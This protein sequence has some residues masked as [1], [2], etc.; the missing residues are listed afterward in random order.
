M[1][2]LLHVVGGWEVGEDEAE[3]DVISTQAR[4]IVFYRVSMTRTSV[5]PYILSLRMNPF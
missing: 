3:V 5:D 4:T 1:W 2:I